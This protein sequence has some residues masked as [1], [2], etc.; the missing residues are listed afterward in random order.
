M[1][2]K[3]SRIVWFVALAIAFLFIL[4]PFRIF[5]GSN[6]PEM[7][8]NRELQNEMD[9]FLASAPDAGAYLVDA[10][11]R[12]DLVMLGETGYIADQLRFLADVIPRL[13]A[14]GIHRLGFQYANRDDQALI[15]EL[16]TGSSFD[17]ALAEEIL[18]RHMVILGYEEHRE[19]FRSAWRVNRSKGEDEEPFRIIGI[20]RTPDYS[21]IEE[22]GDVEDPEILRRLFAD[23]IPDRVMVE[24]IMDEIVEPGYKGLVYTQIEH[25]FTEYDQLEYRET[26]TER[27]LPNERRAGNLLADRLGNRVMTVLFHTPLQDTRSRVG[28]GYPIGGLLD[29]AYEN[30]PAGV[31]SVG[32]DVAASPYAE[33]PITSDVLTEDRED[34]LTLEQLTDGYLLI[35]TIAGYTAVTPIEGFITEENIAT[36]RRQFP[37]PD[38]GEVSAGELNEFI[39]GTAASMTR[40]LEEFE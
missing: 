26:M 21:L 37:G 10:F 5:E 6:I 18:F 39:A 32:F 33:A 15:D 7:R 9:E 22:Q 14:A 4:D 35:S 8:V 2:N 28:Y 24:T 13:D 12:H 23:G 27:G 38:P 40:I 30:L 3:R 16:L 34:E 11:Q 31:T 36:A 1:Q 17:E 29:A 19:V 20:N 25:A